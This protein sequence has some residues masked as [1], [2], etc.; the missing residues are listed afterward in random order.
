[1]IKK[2]LSV[3]LA[4]AVS[5]GCVCPC[6][7]A[8]EPEDISAASVLS[9]AASS[10]GPVVYTA[11]GESV[12]ASVSVEADNE[13]RTLMLC[14]YTE[15]YLTDM[16]TCTETVTGSAELN[17]EISNKCDRITASV[18]DGEGR[19]I[20]SPAVYGAD[21]TDLMYIKVNGEKLEGFNNETDGYDIQASSLSVEAM[22][23]DGTTRIETEYLTG[24]TQAVLTVTSSRGRKRT[25]TISAYKNE[26]EKTELFSLDCLYGDECLTLDAATLSAREFDVELPENVMSIKLVP[27]AIGDVEIF[28]QDTMVTEIDGVNLGM[29]RDVAYNCFE[30]NRIAVDNIIPIKNEIGKAI[31]KVSGAG[32]INEYSITFTARQPRLL[33]LNYTGAA[34][35][36]A[37]PTF[38]GGSAVNND[39]GTLSCMDK[40]WAVVYASKELVGGS[41]IMS[42]G[43]TYKDNS[44]WWMS[45]EKKGEYFNFKAEKPCTVYVMSGNKLDNNVSEWTDAGWTR[46]NN[47]SVPSRDG[48]YGDNSGPAKRGDKTW[49]NYDEPKYYAGIIQYNSA[50]SKEIR[51]ID[52]G[53]S[54]TQ[55]LN[56][57][58]YR[59]F[60]YG[61]KKSFDAEETI[62]IHHTGRTDTLG[63]LLFIV[64]KWDDDSIM[65]APVAENQSGDGELLPEL[66]QLVPQKEVERILY[67]NTESF[68][69]EAGIWRDL[70]GNGNDINLKLDS[71]NEWTNNGY[72]ANFANNTAFPAAVQSVLK[73]GKFTIRFRLADFE[74]ETNKY[75][76][77]FSN[78]TIS[79][80]VFVDSKNTDKINTDVGINIGSASKRLKYTVD[81][82]GKDNVIIMDMPNGC[83]EWYSGGEKQGDGTGGITAV[84]PADKNFV[85]GLDN[86]QFGG[87][88]TYKSME[89][90]DEPVDPSE[91]KV[92]QRGV[93]RIQKETDSDVVNVMLLAKRGDGTSYR[94]E[95]VRKAIEEGDKAALGE[96]LLYSAP[97][98]AENGMIDADIFITGGSGQYTLCINGI[99]ET[100]SYMAED[101]REA[102]IERVI[103]NNAVGDNDL[104]YLCDSIR[105]NRLT[106]KMRAKTL[107]NNILKESPASDA[108][109]VYKA[110]E[111]ALLLESLNENI[112]NVTFEEL[113]KYA[114]GT[115]VPAE[116]A[117][118]IKDVPALVRALS[119]KD[120]TSEGQYKKL[121]SEELFI[122]CMA[123]STSQNLTAAEKKSFF[124]T[125][126][127]AMGLDLSKYNAAGVD[128]QAVITQL[129]AANE[130]SIGGLQAAINRLSV[131]AQPK[132]DSKVSGG[133]GG[134]GGG[135]TV[136]G[137]AAPKGL[138]KEPS[139]DDEPASG[140]DSGTGFA[141]MDMYEWAKPAVEAL[142]A[143]G[144]INGYD[145]NTFRPAN[146]I[147]RA[148]FITLIAKA[149]IPGEPD[150]D[151]SFLDVSES[152][153]F[154]D[155]VMLA[156]QKGIISG[157]SETEF[158]PNAEI[159]RQDMAVIMKNLADMLGVG[160]TASEEEFADSG[161]ISDY[162]LDAASQ[163]R[164]AGIINGKENNFFDPMGL[165]TR[166]EAAQ[167]IWSFMS[168]T[169]GGSL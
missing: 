94:I 122:R 53:T 143:K 168:K 24:P 148:E 46:A 14:S 133:G 164:G 128:K 102:V 3:I 89:I 118:K 129:A 20:M 157:V 91:I 155:S 108:D 11:D 58:V 4:A 56:D 45:G 98:Y 96:M 105:Y 60:S 62:S 9:I 120:F 117:A 137:S 79:H 134:G 152:D 141:D 13:V 65:Y 52:P 161:D 160:L 104:E 82:I 112:N 1:M 71:D 87:S 149:Y 41:C 88:V 64:I 163:L 8:G 151:K 140:T 50:S 43:E 18:L 78:G 154:F 55:S 6:V 74:Q 2:L 68:D 127:Q 169:D 7:F 44:L 166:A 39:N 30:Y 38:V 28:A 119:S 49:N 145:D 158:M 17:A 139:D 126:A 124:E 59:A 159:K 15:G 80:L 29:Y 5:G 146:H 27:R 97:V 114:D 76:P 110:A 83:E 42:Y 67:V 77:I 34:N 86:S 100:L 123:N 69:A 25:I 147:T 31:I 26:R 167:V 47:G 75:L 138:I 131:A 72:K 37:R 144:I 21:T 136:S 85:L 40:G 101:E 103:A 63:C 113:A 35:D 130:T 107:A 125:Y 48:E 90:W 51:C 115:T 66:P 95:D 61:Y 111:S 121:L 135:M 92:V 165:T 54:A 162:A 99:E 70:S 84:P 153:W 150:T 32:V 10:A 93:I 12:T 81:L 22:P 73:S 142:T 36:S 16:V 23:A 132:T 156:Y 19:L 109:S 57:M 33:E 106:N 116:S